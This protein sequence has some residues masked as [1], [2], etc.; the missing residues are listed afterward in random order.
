MRSRSCAH[1]LLSVR[2]LRRHRPGG[3][4]NPSRQRPS[5]FAQLYQRST[6]R[7]G[8]KLCPQCFRAI[9]IKVSAACTASSV[10]SVSIKTRAL[11]PS[12]QSR[13]KRGIKGPPCPQNGSGALRGM[14]RVGMGISDKR[15]HVAA[16]FKTEESAASKACLARRTEVERCAAGRTSG[17]AYPPNARVA[18]P[19]RG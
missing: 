3:V 12:L 14:A 1:K 4:L 17:W 8:R 5:V 19:F 11:S 13:G 10:L 15:A 9:A 18:A 7:L 6:V 2:D 16:S